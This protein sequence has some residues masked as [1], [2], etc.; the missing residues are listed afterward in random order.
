MV[1]SSFCISQCHV[2]KLSEDTEFAAFF[3]GITKKVIVYYSHRKGKAHT[4]NTYLILFRYYRAGAIS[5]KA[6][7]LPS[8]QRALICLGSSTAERAAVNRIMKVQFLSGT[9][10]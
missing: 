9:P 7:S 3:P 5:A 8:N 10:L 2:R 1:F 6:F 4:A